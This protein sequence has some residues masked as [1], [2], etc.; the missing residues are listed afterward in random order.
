M[1]KIFDLLKP[2]ATILAPYWPILLF[3]VGVALLLAVIM[4]LSIIVLPAV[5]NFLTAN[6]DRIKSEQVRTRLHDAIKKFDIVAG[7]I[8]AQSAELA[9]KEYLEIIADGKVAR[10]EIVG[11]AGK[12]SEMAVDQL[13]PEINTFKKYFAG[14]AVKTVFTN[15]FIVKITDYVKSKLSK[16]NVELLTADTIAEEV[17]PLS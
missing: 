6:A 5:V 11:L 14:E 1:E 9:K 7:G 12:F 4:V 17:A 3:S 16:G 2:V 15:L 10:E 8:L 13:G